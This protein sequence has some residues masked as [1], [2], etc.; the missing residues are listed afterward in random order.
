MHHTLPTGPPPVQGTPHLSLLPPRIEI[1]SSE[2]HF[3]RLDS[4]DARF[5][6]LLKVRC[7][8]ESEQL[9]LIQRFQILY[10][11]RW[12]APRPPTG[13]VYLD[14]ASMQFGS[15][16]RPEDDIRVSRRIQSMDVI[17][18]SAFFVLPDPQVPFLGPEALH[19]TAKETFAHQSLR[20][21]TFTLTNW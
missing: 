7:C 11:G 12:C 13:T 8:N 10:A 15:L 5:A 18:R 9:V 21:I 17:E 3:G 2:S 14:V 4:K 19:L 1:V 20:R 6:L 16:L